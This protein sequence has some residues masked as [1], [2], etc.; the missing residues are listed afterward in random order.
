[1][2]T[3]IAYAHELWFF[4]IGLFLQSIWTL[5]WSLKPKVGAYGKKV[6]CATLLP[7]FSR[8]AHLPSLG[9]EPV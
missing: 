2:Y 4:S 7:E 8:G 1:M 3:L 5:P 9:R 6:K